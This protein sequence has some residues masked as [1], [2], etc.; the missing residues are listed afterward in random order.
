[1]VSTQA[2]VC[3]SACA[4]KHRGALTLHFRQKKGLK[5]MY[6]SSIYNAP[7]IIH[8]NFNEKT[9]CSILT[10]GKW[11]K[12]KCTPF[13]THLNNTSTGNAHF[14]ICF[15]LPVHICVCV[16]AYSFQCIHTNRCYMPRWWCW[17]HMCLWVC[18]SVCLCASVPTSVFACT[19]RCF[20]FILRGRGQAFPSLSHL[21]PTFSPFASICFFRAMW[22]TPASQ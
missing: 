16:Q 20:E 14:T 6:S 15:I 4:K 8:L 11:T 1:M 7:Y 21:I 3:T 17:L 12:T 9:N 5:N 2:H 22:V 10:E 19:S 18:V 13:G